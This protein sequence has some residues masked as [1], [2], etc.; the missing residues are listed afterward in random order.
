M[1]APGIVEDIVVDL[2][3]EVDPAVDADRMVHDLDL[4]GIEIMRTASATTIWLTVLVA[5]TSEAAAVKEVRALVVAQ[6]PQAARVVQATVVTSAPLGDLH[7]RLDTLDDDELDRISLRD[8]VETHL[9]NNR[10][11]EQ[12]LLGGWGGRRRRRAS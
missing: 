7:A 12:D 1:A 9:W 11:P 2:T 6:I 4:P 8:L 3:L 5:A 10:H